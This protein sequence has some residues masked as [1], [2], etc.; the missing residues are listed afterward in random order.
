MKTKSIIIFA[1]FVLFSAYSYSQ[2]RK[3][4][5]FSLQAGLSPLNKVSGSDGEVY[6]TGAI[7]SAISFETYFYLFRNNENLKNLALG[8][9]TGFYFLTSE[10]PDLGWMWTYDN[11]KGYMIHVPLYLSIKYDLASGK[12]FIPYIKIDNG[13]SLAFPFKMIYRPGDR[14]YSNNFY[15]GGYCFGANFGLEVNKIF[16]VELS[17]NRINSIISTDYRY[18][19]SW[20]YYE[21][22]LKTNLVSLTIGANF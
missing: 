1:A 4:T 12:K 13:F 7:S 17:Y 21:D 19:G 3:L 20:Y 10:D 22:K 15:G 2:D 5:S 14:T 6:E 11:P 8:A 18:G 9:G 16:S